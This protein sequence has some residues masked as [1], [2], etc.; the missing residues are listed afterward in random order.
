M[1]RNGGHGWAD[2]VGS[3]III[4]DAWKRAQHMSRRTVFSVKLRRTATG[5]EHLRTIFAADETTA[6][7]RAIAKARATLP[8]FAEKKYEGFEVVSCEVDARQ[9]QRKLPPTASRR[10]A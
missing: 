8:L 6:K 2:V 3:A 5:E 7:E 10:V 1:G 9:N 4:V